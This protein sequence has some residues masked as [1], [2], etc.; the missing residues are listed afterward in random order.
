VFVL[1]L[2]I[3]FICRSFHS[4]FFFLPLLHDIFYSIIL[5][6]CLFFHASAHLSSHPTVN[7]I[8]TIF[9]KTNNKNISHNDFFFFL[10]WSRVLFMCVVVVVSML[11]SSFARLV[12]AV[13]VF[14]V[15][16]MTGSSI[17]GLSLQRH[18]FSC[19]LYV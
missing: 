15:I 19:F 11:P 8:A 7:N 17:V 2:P 12:T 5:L 13:F 14:D 3:P 18:I 6:H 10:W 1:S 16:Q 9:T 4:P